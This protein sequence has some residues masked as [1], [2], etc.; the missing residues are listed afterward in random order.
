MPIPWLAI[1]Q[2][3]SQVIGQLSGARDANRYQKKQ[4][5]RVAEANLASALTRGRFQPQVADPG[6]KQSLLTRLAGAASTGLSVADTLKQASRAD[7]VYNLQKEGMQQ[8]LE[9]GR[10]QLQQMSNQGAAEQGSILATL[11]DLNPNVGTNPDGLQLKSPPAYRPYEDRLPGEGPDGPKNLYT[12]AGYKSGLEGRLAQQAQAAAAAEEA[13]F[14]RM[15]AI[16]GM[17][18]QGRGADRADAQFGFDQQRFGA[19]QALKRAELAGQGAGKGSMAGMTPEEAMKAEEGLRKEFT[20][21]TQDFNIIQPAYSKLLAA[22]KNPSPAG[23]V[24]I[25]FGYMKLLDPQSTVREGEYATAQNTGSIPDAIWNTYNKALNGEGLSET[26]QD[27]VNQAQN[28]YQASLANYQNIAQ[29]YQRLGRGY[30]L[31]PNNVV[32]NNVMPGLGSRGQAPAGAA[33]A[34]V[35]AIQVLNTLDAALAPP[36]TTLGLFGDL[37]KRRVNR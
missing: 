29:E 33:A 6:P 10:R 1:A 27:F 7:E 28:L 2:I 16:F 3:G 37:S 32:L 17:E 34:P 12:E 35:G 26:R 4:Q 25:I 5:R 22:A 20:A 24:S 8:G 9:Q 19:E 11:A 18:I 23:D 21:R 15:Q 13:N 36:R 30:G 14:K 31:N